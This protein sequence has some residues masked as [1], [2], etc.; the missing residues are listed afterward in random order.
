M[1][2]ILQPVLAV[3]LVLG[4]LGGALFLLRKRGVVSHGSGQLK[5]IERI[6][7]GAQHALHL[8]RVGERMVLVTTSPGSCQVQEIAE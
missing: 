4:L 6:P 2:D 3:L 8:V 5:L 7:L 1:T